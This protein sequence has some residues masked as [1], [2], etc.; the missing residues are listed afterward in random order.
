MGRYT[1][2]KRLGRQR[3][4]ARVHKKVLGDSD[5]PRLCVYRSLKHMS[6][7]IIDDV[8]GNTLCSATTTSKEFADEASAVKGKAARSGLLGKL[9]AQKA[10]EKG[11]KTIRFD[12]GGNAY[13]GRVR[14]LGEAAREE[15]LVF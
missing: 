7:Q 5:R 11:I 1:S 13:H 14:A 12:R 6:A 3:R 2:K 10:M 9:L 15:G 8:T 4:K